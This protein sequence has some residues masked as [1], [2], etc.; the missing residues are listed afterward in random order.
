MYIIILEIKMV[1]KL[2]MI[3]GGPSEECNISLNS[4]RSVYDHL[5]D[6]FDIKIIFINFELKKF[7][8]NGGFLYSNT[9][10]DFD[11]KLANEGIELTDDQFIEQVKE[12][13]LV[14][15]ILHGV[16][17]E[18]GEIQKILED[19]NVPFVGSGSKSCCSVYNKKNLDIFLNNNKYYNIPK[20]FI[21]AKKDNNIKEI[22]T[23][24]F[25]KNSLS[26]CI[27]KPVEG[28][29]SFGI[30]HAKSI[31]DAIKC[32]SEI[33]KYE[34]IMLEKRCLGKEFTLIVLQNRQGNAVS[35]LPTEIEVKDFGNIIFDTRRKYL[36]TNETHYYCPPRFSFNIIEKIRHEAENLFNLANAKD[37]LRIDGWLLD[38]GNIYFSDFNPIS[39]M[40]Q[41]SFIFQQSAKIG[42]T[43]QDVL[44]YI[45][46]S[47]A[48]RNKINLVRKSTAK[49]DEF[50][51]VN[52]LFGGSTSERQ[53]SLLSGSNVYLKLSKFKNLKVEPF[54]LFKENLNSEDDIKNFKVAHLP[55]NIIL[56]H[57]VEEILYQCSNEN[58]DFDDYINDIRFK[59]DLKKTVFKKTDY[60]SLEEFLD[61]C[62]NDDTYLFIALHGG[63]GEGGKLQKE[64]QK[65]NIKFNGS[66]EETANLCMNKFETSNFINNLS[67][68]G[69]RSAK[70]ELLDLKFD[71]NPDDLWKKLTKLG[72]KIIVKPNSDGSSS[73][74]VIL[75]NLNDLKK[76][77]NLLKSKSVS[78]PEG[79][80]KSQQCVVNMGNKTQQLLFEEFIDTDDF[81]I[82]EG[83]LYRSKKHGWIELTVGVLENNGIY[84]SLNPSI[85]VTENQCVLSVEEKFQ[86]GTGIN[87]TP[88][89]SS[90]IGE[91]FLNKIKKNIEIISEK[92]KIKDYCRIDIFVNTDSEE[93]I[94]IEFNT[95]PALTPSTVIFQQAEKENP[96]ISPKDFIL[97]ISK[98]N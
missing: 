72:E 47:C 9:T 7:I 46:D 90:L 87:I 22:I 64:L 84:H 20:T 74:I 1:T 29:S 77:L 98:L 66:N 39:G 81:F 68:N 40:E 54:L 19:L 13:D 83:K 85:T 63:F 48:S 35:L 78:I 6:Q 86:G 8:I 76:Y 11:F 75:E 88:P 69:V 67:I 52:V 16:F 30:K 73:G 37:F 51:R 59:L 53:V 57:T 80:F 27:I 12:S 36:A 62:K 49:S 21:N 25:E 58:S 24:F 3:C 50:R 17:G 26:E 94:I 79:I 97:K 38:N 92:V 44:N 70:H 14:F 18:N 28:G 91:K 82:N 41:N 32:I 71:I 23:N 33:S 15:P 61:N 2:L 89:P 42:M 93:I 60:F 43:H 56:N 31:D 55:Y 5:E 34:N 45:I 96:Q 95:L 65:R 4:A 10:S